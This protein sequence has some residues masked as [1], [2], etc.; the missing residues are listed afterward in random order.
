MS[1]VRVRPE[2]ELDIFEATIWYENE[3]AD[4]GTAFLG[5]VRTSLEH[6]EKSPR[7]FPV[8]FKDI[9]RALVDRFPFGVFFLIE[10]ED[11]AVIAVI[12]L[13]R[14]PSAWARLR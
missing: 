2:A 7:R 8:V 12:H 13:H 11:I 5:A 9:R 6:V 14:H 4:L 3:Q 1:N 10:D